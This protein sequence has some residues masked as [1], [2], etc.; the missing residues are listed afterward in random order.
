MKPTRKAAARGQKGEFPQQPSSWTA[1]PGSQRQFASGSMTR[2]ESSLM[3]IDRCYFTKH[4]T[5]TV[6]QNPQ[7]RSSWEFMFCGHHLQ[8]LHNFI[9]EFKLSRWGAT[10][11]RTTRRDCPTQLPLLPPSPGGV[12]SSL[13]RSPWKQ[14]P[15]AT[16]CLQRGPAHRHGEG[17]VWIR[18]L[19]VLPGGAWSCHHSPQQVAC[20]RSPQ[21]SR[22]P[23]GRLQ[24]PGLP[25]CCGLGQRARG[26]LPSQIT[27]PQSGHMGALQSVGQVHVPSVCRGWSALTLGV[28]P[29]PKEWLNRK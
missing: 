15:L 24:S 12:H 4:G 3:L 29:W 25:M 28:S 1:D 14:W 19:W 27:A 5:H 8:V 10:G 2:L 13:F 9:L 17:G 7:I 22:D 16:L 26:T 6:A 21:W 11:Q 20:R 18:R 23:V